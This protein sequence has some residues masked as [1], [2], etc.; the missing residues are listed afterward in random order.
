MSKSMK[1]Q[2]QAYRKAMMDNREIGSLADK[3]MTEDLTHHI[4]EFDQAR[5]DAQSILDNHCKNVTKAGYLA[6]AKRTPP[7]RGVHGFD[8]S[9]SRPLKT[10]R[11][12]IGVLPPAA[13]RPDSSRM[14]A[15]GGVS[16]RKI[17]P[18]P[19]RWTP[20]RSSPAKPVHPHSRHRRSLRR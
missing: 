4:E 5:A 16:P 7:E 12:G 20:R 6:D 9:E 3:V 17:S 8:W 14:R 1:E 11:R 15:H 18:A 19:S 2:L 10:V 13:G